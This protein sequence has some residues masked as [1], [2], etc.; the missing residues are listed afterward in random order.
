MKIPRTISKAAAACLAAMLFCAA[1]SPQQKRLATVEPTGIAMEI[2][3]GKKRGL[4]FGLYKWRVLEVRGDM[5]LMISEK[6]IGMKR[7]YHRSR[8]DVTWETCDMRSYLNLDFARKFTA[9]ELSLILET[10][11]QNQNNPI[12][13]TNGGNDTDDKFFLLSIREAD[14]YF[15]GN[16]NR[17]LRVRWWLRSPGIYNQNASW[18]DLDG[19]I[20]ANGGSINFKCGIRPAFWLSLKP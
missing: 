16:A 9:E 14:R 2:K 11:V 5:A 6:T 17:K 8:T 10:K 19:G 13:G 7:K 20:N 4:R 1:A 12:R 18:V 15:G 3:N